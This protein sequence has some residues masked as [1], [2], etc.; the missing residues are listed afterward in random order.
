MWILGQNQQFTPIVLAKFDLEGK[1]SILSQFTP[2][3]PKNGQFDKIST[4]RQNINYVL[5]R[6][7]YDNESCRGDGWS[8]TYF[9]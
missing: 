3:T 1:L 9:S 7:S 6:A 8:K 4:L 5:A 2:K